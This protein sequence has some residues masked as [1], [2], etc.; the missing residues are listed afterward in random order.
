MITKEKLL[1]H[2]NNF[3]KEISIEELIEKLLFIEKIESRLKLS[4]NNETVSE[5][6]L[7]SEMKK[8][9]K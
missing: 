7:E 9:F 8:W 6:E 5:E 1:K 4:D 2:I 3:P